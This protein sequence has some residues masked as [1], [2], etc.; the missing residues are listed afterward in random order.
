MSGEVDDNIV[1]SLNMRVVN[2]T[3]E[4]IYDV[5]A[6]RC[7]RLGITIGRRVGAEETLNMF[8]W[9]TKLVGQEIPH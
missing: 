9:Y 3:V 6:R 1:A 7:H 4:R 2:E 5:G 8:L